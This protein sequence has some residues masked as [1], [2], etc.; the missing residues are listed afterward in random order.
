M[1]FFVSLLFLSVALSPHWESTFGCLFVPFF[2]STLI[3]L[4]LRAFVC[5]SRNT[6]MALLAIFLLFVVAL[7]SMLCNLHIV[8]CILLLFVPE[9]SIWAPSR[10]HW[11]RNGENGNST[12]AQ[13]KQSSEYTMTIFMSHN[14]ICRLESALA[15]NWKSVKLTVV[16]KFD[17]S[18]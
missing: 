9:L 10:S 5:I 6:E 4:L 7:D 17:S 2:P 1:C 15:F 14:A 16:T 3:Y 18:R 11:M 12:F 8:N 13:Y